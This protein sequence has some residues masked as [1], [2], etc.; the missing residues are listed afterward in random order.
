MLKMCCA[1]LAL[2]ST[3][4]LAGCVSTTRSSESDALAFCDV[5][6]GIRWHRNDTDETLR[7]IKPLNDLYL[8]KCTLGREVTK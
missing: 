8:A 5:Y 6:R 2:V 7:Q 4:T 3:L 1:S